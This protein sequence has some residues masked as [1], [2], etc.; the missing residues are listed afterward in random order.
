MG[1][2]PL[3]KAHGK[4]TILRNVNTQKLFEF[5]TQKYDEFVNKHGNENPVNN[6]QAEF[7]KWFTETY[8]KITKSGRVI[9]KIK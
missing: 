4:G 9:W 8:L 5:Y 7:D 2:T 1:T 6:L 3:N